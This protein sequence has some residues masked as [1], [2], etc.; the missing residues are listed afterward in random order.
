MDY[1][2]GCCYPYR[3]KRAGKHVS[4]RPVVKLRNSSCGCEIP[5]FCTDRSTSCLECRRWHRDACEERFY[6]LQPMQRLSATPIKIYVVSAREVAKSMAI[7]QW[8]SD[9]S[10]AGSSC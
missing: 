10:S 8:I 9:D 4:F 2:L 3:G 1:W 6:A 5:V 7:S